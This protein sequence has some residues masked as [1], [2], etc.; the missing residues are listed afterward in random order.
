MNV[1][2][3]IYCRVYQSVFYLLM[4]F[5]PYRKPKTYEDN[6]K[7]IDILKEKSINSILIVTDKGIVQNGI[8]DEIVNVLNEN[9]INF[10]IYDKTIPNPTISN[11]EEA[12]EQY[13]N[14][15]H[16]GIIAVV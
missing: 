14:N 11:V 1:F 3:K 4:P 6:E 8:L 13:I 10:S 15:N 12:R 9:N 7:V 16:Q 2:K 5:L